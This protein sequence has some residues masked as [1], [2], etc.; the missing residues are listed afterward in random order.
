MKIRNILLL[1]VI[2]ALSTSVSA[3]SFLSEKSVKYSGELNARKVCKAVVH[4]DPEKLEKIFRQDLSSNVFRYSSHHV[5]NRFIEESYV[6]NDL[7]LLP[8]ADQI[9]A[10]N[11]SGYLR[12]GRGKVTMEEM[13]STRD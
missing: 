6:C 5:R 8:F 9:G 11:V 2:A 7:A 12:K 3:D 13:V 1:S 4:D 10:V